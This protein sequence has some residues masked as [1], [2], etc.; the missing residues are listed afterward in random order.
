MIVIYSF[1]RNWE[2]T[3]KIQNVKL[4]LNFLIFLSSIFYILYNWLYVSFIN[5]LTILCTFYH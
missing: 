4:T 5:F 2:T 3:E 1:M